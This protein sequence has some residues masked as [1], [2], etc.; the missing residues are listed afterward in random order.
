MADVDS[1]S[2]AAV[3][4][5]L[6][7]AA[8]RT[9]DEAAS[10]VAASADNRY[11]GL[12]S[13]AL[14]KG[15]PEKFEMAVHYPVSQVVGGLVRKHLGNAHEL[16]FLYQHTGFVSSHFRKLIESR[17]GSPCSADKVRTILGAISTFYSRGQKIEWD[18]DQEYTYHL[19][20]RI[21]TTHDVIISFFEGLLHLYYGNNER[22]L[23]ALL[24]VHSTAKNHE[25]PSTL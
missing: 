1:Q 6:L 24:K 22:Y 16:E 11:F 20:R 2:I 7:A 3:L 8:R 5:G 18:Y 17:E 19:P 15:S 13:E 21:F 10:L 4:D 14:Q 9:E 12:A 23:T 25:N